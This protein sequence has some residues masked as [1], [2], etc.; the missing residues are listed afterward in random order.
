MM[1]HRSRHAALTA[2]A[3]SRPSNFVILAAQ[4]RVCSINA[5]PIDL[6]ATCAQT[7]AAAAEHQLSKLDKAVDL[8]AACTA[9][10]GAPTC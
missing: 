10:T 1:T 7:A 8:D 9:A 2:D 6:D 3:A 5:C 4:Q